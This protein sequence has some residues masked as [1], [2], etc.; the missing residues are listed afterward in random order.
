M[1]TVL[2]RPGLGLTLSTLVVLGG[3]WIGVA[4]FYPALH[5]KR[6]LIFAPPLL[7]AT[8]VMFYSALARFIANVRNWK[9]NYVHRI[10]TG[11]FF[12]CIIGFPHVTSM[13]LHASDNQATSQ[14]LDVL[15]FLSPYL[16][17]L[18]LGGDVL[19]PY[20]YLE[21][22]LQGINLSWATITLYGIM[23]VP[24]SAFDFILSR[25]QQAR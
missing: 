7:A 4:A 8:T 17:C 20:P 9:R 12:I 11:V 13:I 15:L 25:R 18:S 10:L 19:S 5:E 14:S 21:Q 3:I 2:F 22:L 16:A 23:L 6:E 1:L 24:L